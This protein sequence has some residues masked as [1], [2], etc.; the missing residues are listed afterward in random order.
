MSENLG[1]FFLTKKHCITVSSFWVLCIGVCPWNP[2]GNFHPQTVFAI[3]TLPTLLDPLSAEA[4]DNITSMWGEGSEPTD[5]STDLDD[6]VQT[7]HGSRVFWV[8]RQS[9]SS[10]RRDAQVL[11]GRHVTETYLLFPANHIAC[12]N[13]HTAVLLSFTGFTYWNDGCAAT[14]N[15]T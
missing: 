12:V 9:D 7:E 5:Y 10:I 1:G 11:A 2:V 14:E 15:A 3:Q 8:R 6:R 13:S 4:P